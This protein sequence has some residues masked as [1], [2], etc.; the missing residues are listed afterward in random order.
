MNVIVASIKKSV[1]V[2]VSLSMCA[3]VCVCVC[4]CVCM[5]TL[6]LTLN[7]PIANNNHPINSLWTKSITFF[8]C[9]S[10][11]MSQ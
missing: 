3:C 9:Q 5:Y 8:S 4:V 10:S 1:F 6:S 2:F 7:R 11:D